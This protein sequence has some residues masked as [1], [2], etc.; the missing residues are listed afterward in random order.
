M[1]TTARVDDHLRGRTL[2]IDGLSRLFGAVSALDWV[3]LDL[4]AGEVNALMG[5]N[6]A[7]K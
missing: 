2:R 1:L 7:G 6:G 4:R 3:N 5:E